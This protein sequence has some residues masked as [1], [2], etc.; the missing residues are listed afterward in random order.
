MASLGVGIGWC[1]FG[2]QGGLFP[3]VRIGVVHIWC[4]RGSM[5]DVLQGYRSALAKALADLK[6]DSP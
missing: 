5:F 2:I 1:G 3:N 6:K 4:C